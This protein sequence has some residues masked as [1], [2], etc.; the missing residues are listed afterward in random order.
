MNRRAFIN[1]ISGSSVG[2]AVMPPGA[3]DPGRAEPPRYV[4]S[5]SQAQ[6]PTTPH[7]RV[8]V[9]AIGLNHGHIY[10]QV[11]TLRRNGAELVSVYA[12]E[13]ELV[14]A[15]TKRHPDVKVARS[16][17]EILE[18]ESVQLVAS[19]G[20]PNERAPLGIRVMQH[21]KDFMVDK[22]GMTTLAQL[23]EARRVQAKTRRIYTVFYGRL[24]S[25]SMQRAV[26]LVHGGAIGDVVHTMGTGPH[27]VGTNRPAWFWQRD[28]YGGIIGDLGTH[29][30]DY[31]IA[32]TKATRGEVVASR[33]GNLR[34]PETPGFEDFGDAMIEAPGATGYFRVD[35]F[36]PG[37]LN[38]FGDSRLQVVGT[39]GY[40]EIRSTVDLAGR[41]GGNHLFLVDQ[42]QT[43][44]I[45]AKDTPLPY[46]ARLLA[47][48]TNRTETAMSQDQTFLVAQLVLEA[49]EKARKPGLS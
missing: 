26:E 27:K 35:W 40:L 12:K 8:R 34:H 11:E 29:Q 10:G 3:F 9:A 46:G 24:E 1:A 42:K 18:D 19:A 31:F 13:P 7:P 4:E 22:P 44:Y 32:F 48:V 20:I 6:A 16:E 49:Q 33:A 14:A 47:D 5:A 25:P 15:F 28:R 38:T 2:M 36:T 43:R 41:P 23:A 37:G 21:G 45:D 39:D 17:Q 30:V